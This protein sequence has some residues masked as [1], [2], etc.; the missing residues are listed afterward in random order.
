ACALL[1][2]LAAGMAT[3]RTRL[4]CSRATGACT[5]DRGS[6]FGAGGER[7][8][9]DSVREVRLVEGLGE[10]G[11]QVETAL[12]LFDG[13]ERRLAGGDAGRARERHREVSEF[14]SGGGRALSHARG[15]APIWWWLGALAGAIAACVLA[16]RARLAVRAARP[17]VRVA[18]AAAPARRPAARAARPAREGP[19]WITRAARNRHVQFMSA[20]LAAFAV[21]QLVLFLIAERAQGRLELECRARCRFPGTECLPG[22]T[23]WMALA[24]GTY[25]IERQGGSGN[26]PW[27]PLSFEIR[28][29]ETTRLVCAHD[30]TSP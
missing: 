23:L 9:I 6:L 19:S 18:R 16:W 2:V 4:D 5:F 27:P 30:D 22:G 10:R 17:P 11:D 3:S 28:V 20:I 8:A 26:A 29:G 21:V 14:F 25:T 1:A 7:F 13:T 15:G 24:P 12:V